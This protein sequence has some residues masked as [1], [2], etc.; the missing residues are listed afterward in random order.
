MFAQESTIFLPNVFAIKTP[1]AIAIGVR[2]GNPQPQKPAKVR[3]TRITGSREEKL[4]KLDTI[5]TFDDVEWQ[6]CLDGWMQP[7]LPK[8]KGDYYAWP[9][10]YLSLSMATFGSAIQTDVANRRN[11]GTLETKMGDFAGVSPKRA[12]RAR[13]RNRCSKG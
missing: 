4:S 10:P 8:G 12:R 5:R 1:V 3:Y 13:S 11:R 9:P 6:D 7:F 2:Y